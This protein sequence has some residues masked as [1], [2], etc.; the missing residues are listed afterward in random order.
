MNHFDLAD[1]YRNYDLEDAGRLAINLHDK[2][3]MPV[4]SIKEYLDTGRE[5]ELAFQEIRAI[6]KCTHLTTEQSRIYEKTFG[7]KYGN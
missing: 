7:E 6:L 1:Q 2:R 5:E 3:F 4:E